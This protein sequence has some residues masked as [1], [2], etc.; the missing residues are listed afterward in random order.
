MLCIVTN[1]RVAGRLFIR[2][3]GYSQWQS[4]DM[5][6]AHHASGGVGRSSKGPQV[7]EARHVIGALKMRSNIKHIIYDEAFPDFKKNSSK[8]NS[9]LPESLRS[10]VP[11]F[12][13]QQCDLPGIW[14]TCLHI[15]IN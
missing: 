1:R 13:D 11:Q 2:K 5:S 3:M 7:P 8:V 9:S 12:F 10:A 4:Q 6:I 14:F 15:G